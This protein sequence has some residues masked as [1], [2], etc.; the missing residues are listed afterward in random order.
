MNFNWSELN[1]KS[2][3]FECALA[4]KM[5]K[6]VALY[7]LMK[8]KKCANKIEICKKISC[9]KKPTN[10]PKS[11]ERNDRVSLAGAKNPN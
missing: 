4:L 3:T 1:G 7:C 11:N 10:P 6:K 9:A 5:L 2:A 8:P